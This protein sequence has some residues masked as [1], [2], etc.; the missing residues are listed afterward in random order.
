VRVRDIRDLLS[1]RERP[2][3]GCGARGGTV[4]S[5]KWGRQGRLR[6]ELSQ[7]GRAQQAHSLPDNC[8][9]P[10]RQEQHRC[11]RHPIRPMLVGGF[12]DR[13]IDFGVGALQQTLLSTSSSVIRCSLSLLTIPPPHFPM[14]KGGA[15]SARGDFRAH[16]RSDELHHHFDNRAGLSRCRAMVAERQRSNSL[17]AAAAAA[18]QCAIASALKVLRVDREMRWR[19]R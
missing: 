7:H 11:H 3:R 9:Q 10:Q 19:C 16:R 1:I 14:S 15:F 2:S 13:L 8:P 17:Q 5:V 18:R 6:G 12:P 4:V